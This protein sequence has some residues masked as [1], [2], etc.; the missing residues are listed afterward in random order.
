MEHH[1]KIQVQHLEGRY[2]TIRVGHYRHDPMTALC[3]YCSVYVHYHNIS[4][5]RNM[6]GRRIVLGEADTI[7]LVFPIA[8]SSDALLFLIYCCLTANA[9]LCSTF[10]YPCKA[11][12]HV[13]YAYQ[14]SVCLQ[15]RK[16]REI[17]ERNGHTV[18]RFF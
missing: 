8:L 16:V 2:L 7:F 13:W 18:Y 3:D 1:V 5:H 17:K 12:H 11:Q 14:A 4:C 6:E 9:Q 10:R 15:T